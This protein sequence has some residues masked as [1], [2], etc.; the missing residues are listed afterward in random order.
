MAKSYVKYQTPKE[1][2]AKALEALTA[3]NDSGRVRKGANEATKGIESGTSQLVLIAEDVEPE[4]VVVHLPEIC[5]EKSIAFVFIPTKK[6]LGGA[7]GLP[8]PCA[9]IAIDK[10]GNAAEMVKAIVDKVMPLCGIVTASQSAK[11][12]EAPKKEAKPKKEKKAKKE[13]KPKKET[14]KEGDASE[15]EKKEEAPKEE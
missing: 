7:C 11:K 9:A 3:A 14:P 8:V 15:E 13:A 4:E 10:P 2:V 6:E 12:E 1:I 5:K